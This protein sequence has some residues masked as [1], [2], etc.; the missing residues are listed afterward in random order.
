MIEIPKL[1]NFNFT[2]VKSFLN[3]FS[4]IKNSKD[5]IIQIINRIYTIIT[6]NDNV[7]NKLF[8]LINIDS[9]LEP[10]NITKTQV[11]HLIK[12]ILKN[13]NFRIHLSDVINNLLTRI[14]TMKEANDYND[15]IKKILND[16]NLKNTLNTI[17]RNT[18]QDLYNEYDFKDVIAKVVIKKIEDTKFSDIFQGIPNKEQI[19]RTLVDILRITDRHISI[20]NNLITSLINEVATNG[21]ELNLNNLLATITQDLNTFFNSSNFEQTAINLLKEIATSSS[22]QNNKTDFYKLVENILDFVI[23]KTD[24]GSMIWNIL[25]SDIKWIYN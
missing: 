18:L 12:V 25:S 3:N 4:T 16:Q 15:L 6:T 2:T 10:Y 19:G 8:N 22:I 17:F 21:L 1:F 7:F 23:Q 20:S 14:D 11:L 9:L 24:L 5:T 13:N